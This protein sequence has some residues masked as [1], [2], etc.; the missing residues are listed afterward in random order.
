MS[1]G[2]R[3]AAALALCF[4]GGAAIAGCA[5]AEAPCDI[6]GGAYHIALPEDAADAPVLLFLH[7]YGSHGGATINNRRLVEPFVDRG[8]AVIAPN[9]LR[10]AP[11]RPAMWRFRGESFAGARDERS[12]FM[13]VVAD[14]SARFGVS[15]DRVLLSG[16]SGG[17]FMV[18]YLACQT[19]ETFT[20][21]APVSGGF[22]RPHP[23][24]CAGPVTLLQS[25]GWMDR[26][27]PL[28]GRPLGGGQW[29]QGDIWGGMELWRDANGCTNVQPDSSTNTGPFWHRRWDSCASGAQLE[30]VLFPGGHTVPEGWADVAADWFE[31]AVPE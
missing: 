9:A 4:G 3:C 20:A 10:P 16:F 11:G 28:E 13:D 15:G 12:F 1:W 2:V 31:A 29:Q 5:D 8:Y 23:E 21:Y 25:H 22:W 14:A 6:D 24:I 17:A 26:T 19:P 30:F 27:V 18:S 7:G